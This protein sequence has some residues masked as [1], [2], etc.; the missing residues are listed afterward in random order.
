MWRATLRG[1]PV[2]ATVSPQNAE[3]ALTYLHA[4]GTIAAPSAGDSFFSVDANITPNK[5]NAHMT[6]QV[7]DH[8]TLDAAGAATHTLTLTYKWRSLVMTSTRSAA[9]AP[10]TPCMPA[11]DTRS[12]IVSSPE[13]LPE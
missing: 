13:R 3:S 6:Y 2:F 9:A 12:R 8:V 11:S 4:D 1:V 7:A 5:A 10:P